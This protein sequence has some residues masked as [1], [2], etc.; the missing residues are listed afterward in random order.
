MLITILTAG[1]R[2]DTQPFIALGL[3]LK[4]AGYTVQIAASECFENFVTSYGLEFFPIKGD[5]SKLASSDMAKKAMNADNPV[6][7]F[8]SFNNR[9]MKSLLVEMQKEFFNACIGSDVIIYHPGAPIGYFAAQHFKIPS[10]LATPF[11]MTPTKEY[12]SLI[13]YDT[14]RLGKAFNFLT[15]KIFEKGFWLALRSPVKEFWKREFGKIPKGF[16]CP[17]SKQKTKDLPTVISCSTHVFPR[18]NDWP[19]YVGSTGYWFLDN[20]VDWK[21]STELIDFLKKGTPP[22]YVGFGSIGDPTLAAQ[23]TELVI[24]ALK[25]A[26]QRGI[27]ATGWS[28]MTKM[29]N[30]PDEI[31]I[32]ESAPHAWLFP[33]MAAVV[34][35]GGAGTTA[36]GL[37]AGVPSVIIPYGN[38][39][40]AWGRRVYEL[41]VGSKPIPRKQLTREKLSDAIQYALGKEIKNAAKDLG[42]K[43]RNENGAEAAAKI[44]INC[45][46]QKGRK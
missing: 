25:R 28:G 29:N 44:I 23:T 21:P 8:L 41:G 18:P 13:F 34:H 15:H 12:P 7:F 35:H 43:I 22:V 6:K 42:T 36:A 38:D 19:E 40:F 5:I 31:L 2:G 33:Q 39:Q 10:I 20:E 24:D 9:I 11:P 1:T 45:L 17:F 4:K 46:K 3:E 14:A 32:L 16:T 26:G 27:L 30:I 37:R